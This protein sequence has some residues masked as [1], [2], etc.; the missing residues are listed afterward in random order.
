MVTRNSSLYWFHL[1]RLQ[2]LDSLW[3]N[4]TFS[5]NFTDYNDLVPIHYILLYTKPNTC[6]RC[7]LL[8]SLLISGSWGWGSGYRFG[9]SFSM[10]S[11]PACRLM[12]GQ[13]ISILVNCEQR[14]TFFW[15]DHCSFSEKIFLLMW[16]CYLLPMF[17]SCIQSQFTFFLKTHLFWKATIISILAAVPPTGS[18]RR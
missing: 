5:Q 6:N 18:A 8:A 17:I 9:L 16:S 1:N 2:A 13:Y 14:A 15:N 11:A 12:V 4:V 7:H 3:Y 10:H